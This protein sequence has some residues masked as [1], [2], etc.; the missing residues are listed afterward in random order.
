MKLTN[1][2]P[3]FKMRVDYSPTLTLMNECH[4][5]YLFHRNNFKMLDSQRSQARNHIR[6]IFFLLNVTDVSFTSNSVV[7]NYTVLV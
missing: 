6:N 5:N 7:F 1:V 3:V 4:W 2:V